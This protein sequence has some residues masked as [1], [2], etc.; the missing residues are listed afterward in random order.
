MLSLFGRAGRWRR[1]W[2]FSIILKYNISAGCY[3]IQTTSH[4]SLTDNFTF[5]HQSLIT[6]LDTP[7]VTGR[8]SSP[9]LTF[10]SWFFNIQLHRLKI[11]WNTKTGIEWSHFHFSKNIAI[12]LWQRFNI[13]ES[14]HGNTSSAWILF[15]T[16]RDKPFI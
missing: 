7:T 13:S 12:R 2:L 10:S 5:N 3:S 8:A 16:I 1:G 15:K 4:S 9:R 11:T 14:M 6:L